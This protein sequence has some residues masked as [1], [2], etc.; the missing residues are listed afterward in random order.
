MYAVFGEIEFELITYFDGMEASFGADYAE[1]ALI[2]RKPRLQ[3]VGE[4]LD[5]ITIELAF[6]AKYCD[7][8]AEFSKLKKA[9]QSREAGQ[10]VLGSGEYKGWFVITDLKL[11]CRQTDKEGRLI[12]VAASMTLRE[13]VIPDLVE[14]KKAKG[15]SEAQART[16]AAPKK[17]S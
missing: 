14:M 7:P 13:Y 1:H 12:E 5:E 6:H 2:G 4:K 8:E 17:K 16:A 15:K 9:M 3:F 10:F 11:T